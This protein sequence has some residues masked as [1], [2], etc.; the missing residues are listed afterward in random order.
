MLFRSWDYTGDELVLLSVTTDNT[1]TARELVS[2]VR[3][4]ADLE[5][6]YPPAVDIV[7]KA[8]A[9]YELSMVDGYVEGAYGKGY[10]GYI[11]NN[12]F[13]MIA[14]KDYDDIRESFDRAMA[15]IGVFF[16]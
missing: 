11:D 13:L 8:G 16:E 7:T 14:A 12:A 6:Y 5:D 10:M 9:N 2:A 1:E 15:E 3:N 4:L